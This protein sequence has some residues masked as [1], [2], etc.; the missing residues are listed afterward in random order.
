MEFYYA[1]R[2]ENVRNYK[3]FTVLGNSGFVCSGGLNWQRK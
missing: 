1:R 2:L 3:K